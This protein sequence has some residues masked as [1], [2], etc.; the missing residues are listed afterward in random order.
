MAVYRRKLQLGSRAPHLDVKIHHVVHLFICALRLP[1]QIWVN[2]VDVRCDYPQFL[3][4]CRL[5][6]AVSI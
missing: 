3:D 2:A 1:Q 5:K 6:S 4:V